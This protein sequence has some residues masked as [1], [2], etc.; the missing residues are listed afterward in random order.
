M[1]EPFDLEHVEAHA[2]VV[3]RVTCLGLASEQAED[4]AGHRVVVLVRHLGL[5]PLVEVVDREGPVD[6]HGVLVDL[7]DRFV[8]Q[9]ELVLDVPDDLLEQILERDDPL[10]VAVL[11]DDDRHVL[12]RAP[13]LR[14]QRG[15]VLRLGDDVRGPDDVLAP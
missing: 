7:L 5:E 3:D 2:V 15:E 8:R 13:E 9:V 6:D 11:V 10:H 4:E 14:E 1:R 12:V